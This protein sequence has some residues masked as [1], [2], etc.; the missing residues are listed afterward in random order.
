MRKESSF[1]KNLI[2]VAGAA[3]VAL[4]LFKLMESDVEAGHLRLQTAA[5][6]QI[7]GVRTDAIVL[8][9]GT[10]FRWNCRSANGSNDVDKGSIAGYVPN[11]TEWV[12]KNPATSTN[13]PGWVMFTS[14]DFD[15]RAA[16]SLSERAAST[17]CVELSESAILPFQP[18]GTE[19]VLKAHVD[20]NGN[21]I[22]NKGVDHEVASSAAF[23][24]GAAGV[25]KFVLQGVRPPQ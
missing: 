3:T 15:P 21:F 18:V 5:V 1:G 11:G 24:E 19:Q 25:G 10:S 2:R 23:P 4:A 9:S 14:P 20:S 6:E 7:D 17:F 12:V 16:Q 13:N 22:T 8:R